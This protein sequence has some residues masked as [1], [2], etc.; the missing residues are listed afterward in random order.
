MKLRP[1]PEPLELKAWLRSLKESDFSKGNMEWDSYVIWT[2]NKLPKYLWDHWKEN[3]KSIGI[4][5]QKFLRLLRYRTDVGVMWYKGALPWNDF[6]ARVSNLIAG[7]IGN[8]LKKETG[9]EVEMPVDIAEWQFPP[10]KDWEKFERVC[11]DLWRKIWSDKNIQRIGRS[12]QRQHGVD[13]FGTIQRSGKPAGIQ[14]KKKDATVA[15][16]TL[17]QLE[18]RVIVEDA[19]SFTPH[20]SELIVAY[21]GRRDAKLQKEARR[22]TQDH[23]RQGLFVVYVY[24]WDDVLEVLGDHGEVLKKHFHQFAGIN[25]DTKE[26]NRQLS[27]IV[28]NVGRKTLARATGNLDAISRFAAQSAADLTAIAGEHSAEIDH[29]RDLLEALK[30]KE[31]FDYLEKLEKRIWTSATNLIRF[32]LLTNKAAAL[33]FLRNDD[34]D[35]GQLFIEA[36]QYNPDDEKALSNR[37]V[38]H[39][40]L[41]QFTEAKDFAEKVIQKN[42]T[43]SQAFAVLVSC[44]SDS[45]PMEKVIQCIPTNIRKT[46]QGAYAIA[47]ATRRRGDV[48]SS[49]QWFEVA[50]QC[51]VKGKQKNP[52]L[53]AELAATLLQVVMSKHEVLTRTHLIPEDKNKISRARDLLTESINEVSES[54][55]LNYRSSWFV[56]RSTAHE[57]L[58]ELDSALLDIE[59][60][61]HARP[62]DSASLNQKSFL[63]YLKGDTSKAIDILYAVIEKKDLPK[64]SLLLA[65]ILHEKGELDAA[66][67]VLREF[68]SHDTPAPLRMEAERLLI[69]LHVTQGKYE[70]AREVSATLRAAEPTQVLNLVVASRIEKS[71]GDIVSAT[72][73]LDEARGYV[74]ETTPSHHL[75]ELADDLYALEKYSDAWPLYERLVD[76]RVNNRLVKQLLYSYFR[77]DEIE[78]A[79]ALCKAIP[80]QEKSPFAVQIELSILEELNDLE[81]AAAVAEQFLETHPDNFEIRVRLALIHFRQEEFGKLDAFLNTNVDT[82]HLSVDAGFRLA[83]LYVQRGMME[84]ALELAYE[85]RRRHFDNGDAHLK[86]VGL[87]FTGEQKLDSASLIPEKTAIGTAVRVENAAHEF[88]WHLLEDRP[89]VNVTANEINVV[90]ELGSKLVNKKVG[91]EVILSHGAFSDTVV[92]IVEIK[93]KYVYVLHE[94]LTLLPD[95]FPEIKGFERI[96]FKTG[97][98]DEKRETIEKLLDT[99]VTR[100]EQLKKIEKFYRESHLTIGAIAELLGKNVIDI[101]PMIC[102]W[103]LKC[104]LGTVAERENA[105]GL[106]EQSKVIAMD[107]TALLTAAE[108]KLLSIIDRNFEE[109]LV[110]QSTLDLLQSAIAER[111]GIGAGGYMTMRKEGN[112][113]FREEITAEQINKQIEFLEAVKEWIKRY[114]NVRPSPVVTKFARRK[115][116]QDLIGRSFLD[117]IL[118]A[119]ENSCPLYTDDYGTKSLA[120][121]DADFQ[122]SGVW[123]QAVAMHA[124]RE[125]LITEDEYNNLV[126]QLVG[127]NYRH[128]TISG[129]TVL[130]AAKRAE[131]SSARPYTDVLETFRGSQTE[132]HSAVAVFSDFLFLLWQQPLLDSKRE[133]LVLCF[134]DVLTD[135]RDDM[136]VLKLVRAAIKRKFRLLPLAEAKTQ[137]VISAW[138]LLRSR[139]IKLNFDQESNF[140]RA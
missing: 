96:T 117:T 21:T 110:C 38:G 40:L 87:F 129:P 138:E 75:I 16:N 68:F 115:E 85:L 24:S 32:R 48:E 70:M 2:G 6:V 136:V 54:E 17:D 128:T 71:A 131:W 19:K 104:C 61:I 139:V 122:V 101:W 45:D 26:L 109:I 59:A 103:G 108:L 43:N 93:S 18:L 107:I 114:S 28:E 74:T 84:R 23:L 46:E 92:K 72:K 36:H 135:M 120:E 123:T 14:C 10:P 8:S 62:D 11:A 31:A 106:L 15:D 90:T 41:G 60:A 53:R 125:K 91:E 89:D 20:L 49:L 50:L 66:E 95:R 86:Y 12:G 4:T 100:R 5:W 64:A 34:K 33:L 140:G 42:P 78:K 113:I 22:I 83:A 105:L 7:P 132:I 112:K 25:I 55:T 13:I 30:H 102:R 56:N 88:R 134:L 94:S 1:P 29:A 58:G 82:V 126:V 73:L 137:Q 127:L 63:L 79:L 47:V 39:L 76:A 44:I 9:I 98:D 99:D 80:L 69:Q 111:Q 67:K 133:T 57:L 27:N 81:R 52:D 77:S 97:S 118:L 116:I 35:A 51:A 65:G 130:E 124:L 3:L 121:N 37:A 119:K